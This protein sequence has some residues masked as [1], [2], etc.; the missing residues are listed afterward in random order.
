MRYFSALPEGPSPSSRRPTSRRPSATTTCDAHLAPGAVHLCS[1]SLGLAVLDLYRYKRTRRSPTSHEQEPR[2]LG[3]RKL[4]ETAESVAGTC[5]HAGGAA[6]RAA[7]PK[8]WPRVA[9]KEPM[10]VI[11][12]ATLDKEGG[13]RSGQLQYGRHVAAAVITT[14]S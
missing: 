12:R 5:T 8:S 1:R 14:R 6:D 7:Q 11:A 3:L 9:K 2:H 10:V 13:G 4:N